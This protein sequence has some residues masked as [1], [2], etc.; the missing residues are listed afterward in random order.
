M[1][2]G[3]TGGSLAILNWRAPKAAIQKI[4]SPPSGLLVLS[5]L[6]TPGYTGG[7]Q[8]ITSPR[9]LNQDSSLS[10]PIKLRVFSVQIRVKTLFL[11]A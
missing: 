5:C 7:H 11:I 3:K 10:N 8:C 1:T 6:P 2:P 9:L 4:V